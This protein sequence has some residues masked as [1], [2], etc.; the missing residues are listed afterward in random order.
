VRRLS[1]ALSLPIIA[2]LLSAAPA[3]AGDPT[4]LADSFSFASTLCGFDGTTNVQFI[5]N[6][7]SYADGGSYDSGQVLETFVADNNRGVTIFFAGH[8]YN[9]PPVVNDDGTITRRF[10]YSEAQFKIQ[11]LHGVLLQQNAGRLLVTI[12]RSPSGDVLS[13]TVTVLAGPNPNT[14]GDENSAV[15]CAVIGPYLGGG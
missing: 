11:A 7:G 2:V 5:D 12:V 1:V 8:E 13:F 15:S 3:A 4:H 10:L 6:F 14:T 9:Y